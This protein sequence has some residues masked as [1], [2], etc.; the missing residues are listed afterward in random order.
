MMSVGQVDNSRKHLIAAGLLAGEVRR[1]PGYQLP[2]WHLRVPDLWERSTA[3]SL[4]HK[5]IKAR[6]A[7]KRQQQAEIRAQREAEKAQKQQ[8]FSPG[9]GGFSSG[10]KPTTPGEKTPLP[11]E[12]KNI[13][14][15]EP[16]EQLA[17][18]I[19]QP[20]ASS[21]TQRKGDMM[22]GILHFAGV[23]AQKTAIEARLP[24]YPPDVQ[25]TLKALAD[26]W[27]WPEIPTRPVRGGKGGAYAQWIL[28]L[29]EINGL[30]AGHGRE[31]LEATHRAWKKSGF[32]V[33]HPGALTK[34]IFAAVSELN[35]RKARAKPA[36]SKAWWVETGLYD[37]DGNLVPPTPRPPMPAELKAL[38][39]R[40]AGAG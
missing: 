14:Q 20:T 24:E 36:D 7:F 23:A 28:E 15:E 38:L 10:E 5:T 40:R 4:E 6:L 3:W 8:A 17:A 21:Q 18:K 25:D 39:T 35:Q 30:I 16:K 11:G 13:K 33:A 29:R 19:A 1:D 27:G 37:A 32:T 26:L 2:V 31:A 22:D 9:E 34:T 12:T